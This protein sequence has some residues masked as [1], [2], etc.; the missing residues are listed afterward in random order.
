MGYR[1]PELSVACPLLIVSVNNSL[2][3]YEL[4][5]LNLPDIL[6]GIAHTTDGVGQA[7]RQSEDLRPKDV[8]GFMA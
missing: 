6:C 2:L 8:P 5:V 4:N 3:H 7:V 1:S